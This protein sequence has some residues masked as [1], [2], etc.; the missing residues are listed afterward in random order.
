MSVAPATSALLYRLFSREVGRTEIVHRW[1]PL[2][3][4][5]ADTE[6][7]F[8]EFVLKVNI[9]WRSAEFAESAK[10]VNSIGP[11]ELTRKDVLV[12]ISGALEPHGF[13]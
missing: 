11:F 12:G 6:L 10:A 13:L 9:M 4:T 2:R 7:Q 1:V 3:T 8:R 5:N